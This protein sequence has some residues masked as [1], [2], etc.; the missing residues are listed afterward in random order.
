MVVS[1]SKG[2]LNFCHQLEVPRQPLILAQFLASQDEFEI[3]QF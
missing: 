1:E 2:A 3:E